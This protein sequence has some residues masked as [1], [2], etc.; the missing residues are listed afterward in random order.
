MSKFNTPA[1]RSAVGHGPIVAEATPSG[2]THEGGPGYARDAKS[3]LFL[4]AVSNMVGEQTFYEPAGDRDSR[5]A[6]L[7]KQVTITDPEWIAGFLGWLRG[8]GNMRSASLVGALEAAK[9]MLDAKIPGARPIVASVLQRA[10]EPG[11]ALGYWT[12]R[13]GRTIPKPVKRGVADA[14]QRLYTEYALLKYDTVSH[15]YRFADVIDLVHPAPAADK[16]WQGALFHHAL[17]RRHGRDWDVNDLMPTLPMVAR[18]AVLRTAAAEGRPFWCDP[19]PEQLREAGLTWE[20]V[21]S[22]AGGKVDK[23][24]LWSA[25]IP[26]MGYMA[27]LRNLR[28]F[29]QASVPDSIAEQVTKRLADPEQ[30]AK[31]RQFPFRFYAAFKAVQSL[32][33][34]HSLERALAASLANVPT[35]PGRTL[36]VVDQSPSMFPGYYFSTK[37]VHRDISNADLAKLFGCAV[38]LRAGDATLVG[39]GQ[40]SYRVPFQRGHALLRLMENFRM[41]DGTDTFG[42][43]GTHFNRHDRVVAITDEQNQQYAHRSID[44]VV[45]REVP[46]YVWNIGGN[47]MGATTSGTAGHNRLTFGGMTDAAFR[48]IP[49]I[50]AGRSCSWPWL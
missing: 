47:E 27:L 16:A 40:T 48:M 26:S 13:Y 5:Y 24:K 37:Q 33:W 25:L 46:I 7:V 23:A 42:A 15:G 41:V 36:I 8:D 19:D 20:D 30:V 44:D 10:D 38:A 3:E 12:S 49:L 21:L 29:D 1:T 6:Q 14:V 18:N 43:I 4:L 45:P 39:Y 34:G 2:T 35:L 50:E 11:E 9:A 32:R 17:D 31:S 28:N 22:L